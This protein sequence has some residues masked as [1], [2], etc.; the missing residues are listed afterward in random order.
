MQG[1]PGTYIVQLGAAVVSDFDF[2]NTYVG[3]DENWRTFRIPFEE[4]HQEGFGQQRIWTGTDV[5]HIAFYANLTGPF[6]FNI[7][8]IQFYS[9][10]DIQE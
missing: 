7:D 6:T 8:D 3:L 10:Q 5:T 4:F 1:T 2:Y 9:E